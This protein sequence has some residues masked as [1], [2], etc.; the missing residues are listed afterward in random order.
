[1]CFFLPQSNML[2]CSLAPVM[3]LRSFSTASI[4]LVARP[5]LGSCLGATVG[6]STKLNP[7][8]LRRWFGLKKC[9][10]VCVCVCVWVWITEKVPNA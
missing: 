8:H 9:V 7:I 6:Y 1:L 5:K 2:S 10:C 4:Y 3:A